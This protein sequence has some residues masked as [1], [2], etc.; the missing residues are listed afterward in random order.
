MKNTDI[1]TQWCVFN[2]YPIFRH[3]IGKYRHLFGKVILYPSRHHGFRDLEGFAKSVFKETWVESVQIDYGTEDWRQ[4]ETIPLLPHSDAEWIWFREQDFFVDDWD[5]FFEDA[6]RLQEEADVFGWWHGSQFPYVHPCCLF[7]KREL[8]EQTNKDFRAHPEIPGCD[9]FAMITRDAERLGAKIVKLQDI[10]YKN[11]KNAFHLAGLT[12]PY[13]NWSTDRI[14]GVGN[15][16]A[17]TAYNYYSREFVDLSPEYIDL[18]REIEDYLVR[19]KLST[20]VEKI[21]EKWKPFFK[22]ES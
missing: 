13:Q 9:H 12:Y 16:E 10:G 17:F 7:I 14:F 6:S 11:W 19:H 21:V 4:A 5:K 20:P 22:S 18:S 2:D 1:L 15:I 8:L 3:H